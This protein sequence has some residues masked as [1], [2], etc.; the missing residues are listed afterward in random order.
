M[1]LDSYSPFVIMLCSDRKLCNKYKIK[2]VYYLFN[3]IFRSCEVTCKK[4]K[5]KKICVQLINHSHRSLSPTLTPPPPIQLPSPTLNTL[6][7]GMARRRAEG[8]YV[9]EVWPFHSRGTHHAGVRRAR[10]RD[11]ITSQA[12]RPPDPK[13]GAEQNWLRKESWKRGLMATTN[14]S[15]S[16]F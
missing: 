8:K 2:N 16:S 13:V 1:L 10:T 12:P 3:K 9:K 11:P 14:V 6:H 15:S 5:E 7:E 4:K